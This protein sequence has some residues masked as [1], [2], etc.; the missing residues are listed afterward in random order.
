MATKKKTITAT[1]IVKGQA[2]ATV[3]TPPPSHPLPDR[4]ADVGR[5]SEKHKKSVSEL[6]SRH[7]T[8]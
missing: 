5:K 2:R 7:E 6:E 1:K 3:G 8:E 4:R